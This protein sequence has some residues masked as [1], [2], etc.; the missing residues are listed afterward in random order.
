MLSKQTAF[1]QQPASGPMLISN[2]CMTLRMQSQNQ[3][4]LTE[5]VRRFR[6]HH[7]SG[8]RFDG[9][10]STET[11]RPV[12]AEAR[13]ASENDPGAIVEG[14]FTAAG[15][16]VRVFDAEGNLLGASPFKPGDDLEAV[17]R[18]LLREKRNTDFYDPIPYR[19]R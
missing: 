3:I 14:A 15:G 18:R 7:D 11:P 4:R 16:M 1:T 12:G 8:Q 6:F 19:V 5:A 2:C 9:R 13:P 17:A 10:P